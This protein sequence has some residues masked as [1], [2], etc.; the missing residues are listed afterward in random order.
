MEV[1]NRL[2]VIVLT[3]LT[4]IS[5]ERKLLSTPVTFEIVND[6]ECLR[7]QP[8]TKDLGVFRLVPVNPVATLTSP[9]ESFR[10]RGVTFTSRPVSWMCVGII[11][12]FP[13][14]FDGLDRPSS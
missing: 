11:R 4:E 8:V 12:N 7:G 10:D 1:K 13:E 14:F 3:E 2:G 9:F 6:L 5:P